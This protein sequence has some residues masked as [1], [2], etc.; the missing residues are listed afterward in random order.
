M[1]KAKDLLEDEDDEVNEA[2]ESLSKKLEAL[3]KDSPED[4]EEDLPAGRQGEDQEEKEIKSLDDRTE[5][6][7]LEEDKEEPEETSKE[8]IKEEL[9]SPEKPGLDPLDKDDHLSEEEVKKMNEKEQKETLTSETEDMVDDK[10][11]EGPTLDDLAKEEPIPQLGNASRSQYFSETAPLPESGNV[12]NSKYDGLGR[13]KGSS[14]LHIFILVLLGLAIIGGTVYLL[15]TQFSQEPTPTP[16]PEAPIVTPASEPTPAPLDR[17]KFKIRVLNGTTKSGLAASVSAKLKDL[18]YQ[19]DKVG[20]ATNSAFT[21]TVVRVK[22]SATG[23]LEQLIKD[24]TPDFEASS[25]S[26]LKDG[27]SAD[28]EVILGTR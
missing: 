23:L 24:L 15:R 27:D 16:T 4:Q 22:S 9:D 26:S 17:S 13:P 25:D 5:D 7:D 10:E 2:Y 8:Q 12:F 3:R 21:R 1:V 18:G 11:D 19:S 20:N 28:A 6:E 14:K